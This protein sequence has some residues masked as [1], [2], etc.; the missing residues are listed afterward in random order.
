MLAATGIAIFLIPAIFY[1]VEKLT[2]KFGK[3]REEQ[4]GSVQPQPAP[5]AGD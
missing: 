4:G 3:E 2:M 5:V 1:L